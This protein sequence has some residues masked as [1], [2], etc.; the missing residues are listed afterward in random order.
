MPGVLLP[1]LLSSGGHRAC[2]MLAKLNTFSL[3]GIEALPVEVEVDV[4]PSGLPKTVLVALPEAAVKESTHPVERAIARAF[5]SSSLGTSTT[6]G[7]RERVPRV[8][9]PV[10]RT[11]PPAAPFHPDFASGRVLTGTSFCARFP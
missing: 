6:N 7:R 9:S 8:P 3:L 11:P 1:A 10:S 2:R 5:P 4:A